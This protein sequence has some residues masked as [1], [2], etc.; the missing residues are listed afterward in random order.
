MSGPGTAG[1]V[2]WHSSAG[3]RVTLR[4]ESVRVAATADTGPP[5]HRA[6]NHDSPRGSGWRQTLRPW[7]RLGPESVH[8]TG[9]SA[10]APAARQSESGAAAGLMRYDYCAV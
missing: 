2:T 6:S 10:A 9:E 7:P 1:A 4:S 3:V 8:F 5:A